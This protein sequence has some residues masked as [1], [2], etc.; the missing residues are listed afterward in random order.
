MSEELSK[1]DTDSKK[2]I[3]DVL[4]AE[5]TEEIKDVT[6]MFNLMQAKKNLLRVMQMN[7]VLDGV[8]KQMLERIDKR[9]GDFS[10]D[11]LVSY[12]NSV[13]NAIDKTNKT[14]SIDDLPMI[15]LNQTN[16]V[17]VSLGD[18][19]DRD[20]RSRIEQAI[21]ALLNS[22]DDNTIYIEKED[23]KDDTGRDDESENLSD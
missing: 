14:V 19:F 17:T 3:D 1:I 13:Q 2:L 18:T 8:T 5:T 15:S 23:V 7:N 16:N 6:Q 20:S 11:D 9:P 22:T 4:N 10:N 21:K 12:L